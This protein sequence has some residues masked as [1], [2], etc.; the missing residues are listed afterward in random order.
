MLLVLTSSFALADEADPVLGKAGDYVIKKSDF[1][2]MVSSLP[3]VTQRSLQTNPEQKINLVK[4]I[5]EAKVIADRAKKEGVGQKPEDIVYLQFLINNFLAQEYKTKVV[6]KSVTITEEDLKKYYAAN[7]K[8]YTDP[9]QVK[10]RHIL[11]K[12]A[13]GAPEEEKKKAKEKAEGLL[14]RLKAGEDFSKL[15]EEFSEDPS[16]KKKGGDLGFF[17]RGRMVKPFEETAFSLKA[18]QMSGLVETQFGYHIIK[19]EDRKEAKVKPL[20]EVREAVKTQVETEMGRLKVE[21]F[22]K[23][24]TQEAGIEIYREKIVGKAP[25]QVPPVST[26]QPSPG[27]GRR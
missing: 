25:V 18:G 5:L 6:M 11:I 22:V 27:G 13:A 21:E 4:M 15:A 14:K 20:E 2:K 26:R 24:V 7:E 23:K 1:D 19:M 10:A 8:K 12:V 17:P 16:S 9:E 3:P